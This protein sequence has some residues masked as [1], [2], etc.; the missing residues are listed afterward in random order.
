MIFATTTRGGHVVRGLQAVR[1]VEREAA[2]RELVA[3]SGCLVNAMRGGLPGRKFAEQRYQL[4]MSELHALDPRSRPQRSAKR[5]PRARRSVARRSDPSYSPVTN[6]GAP[7]KQ[8]STQER[9]RI[10]EIDRFLR[11]TE[12]FR[13]RVSR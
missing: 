3:A 9:R 13:M 8:L 4:A 2:R 11:E 12:E 10:D 7:R 5:P 1:D 6:C